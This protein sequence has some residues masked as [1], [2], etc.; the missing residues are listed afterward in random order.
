MYL[1]S[2]F[3]RNH[4]NRHKAENISIQRNEYKKTCKKE[5]CYIQVLSEVSMMVVYNMLKHHHLVGLVFLMEKS[6]EKHCY[7]LI[8]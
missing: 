6:Q 3:H 4:N 8:Q 5:I 7:N 2:P 1:I